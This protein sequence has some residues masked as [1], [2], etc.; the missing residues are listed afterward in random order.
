MIRGTCIRRL[1]EYIMTAIYPPAISK[2]S[3]DILINSSTNDSSDFWLNQQ[4]DNWKPIKGR[5]EQS[6]EMSKLNSL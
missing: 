6:D 4:S 5:L 3:Y 2:T 1:F